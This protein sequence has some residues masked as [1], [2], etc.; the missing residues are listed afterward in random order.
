[1]TIAIK[2]SEQ[3]V[4]STI[5][6]C[7]L[8]DNNPRKLYFPVN[9]PTIKINIF[10]HAV[11]LHQKIDYHNDNGDTGFHDDDGDDD[12]DDVMINQSINHLFQDNFIAYYCQITVG[13]LTK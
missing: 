13:K 3:E 7:K 9:V 11:L 10:H 2:F 4:P 6:S 5:T 8:R 12:N 1:M